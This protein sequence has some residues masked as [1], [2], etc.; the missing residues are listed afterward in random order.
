MK[1]YKIT[2]D[3][4]RDD[5]ESPVVEWVGTQAEGAK[6]RKHW[7]SAE[8]VPRDRIKTEEVEV[9]TDKKG[10]LAFLNAKGE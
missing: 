5:G 4:A 8:K 3:I 1:L 9:P 2:V 10:L 6:V 7:N